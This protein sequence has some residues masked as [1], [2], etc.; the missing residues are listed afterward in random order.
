MI[1]FPEKAAKSVW[2]LSEPEIELALERIRA[3]R[4]DVIPD[5]FSW[6]KVLVNFLDPKLYGFSVLFFLLNLVS[7]SMSYFL[8]IILESGMG[9][10]EN[11]SIVLSAPV[12]SISF[13]LFCLPSFCSIHLTSLQPYYWAVIPVLLTS[14]IGDKYRL[15]GPAIIFNALVLIAG[16]LMFGLSI[17]H[18]VTVRYIGTYL[19]TGAYVSNWAALNAYQA[20]NIVGQWKRVA[21]A[22]AVTAC[23]GLGGIAGSFIVRQHE[24]P[25]YPTAVWVSI[26]SHILMIAIVGGF[27]IYFKM[28]N[29]RQRRRGK[30][31]EGTVRISFHFS[32][33]AC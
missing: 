30:I 15:R 27:T 13:P 26:G 9:F 22:A 21:I 14:L 11:A 33:N 23:N 25:W 16:F 20:N 28:E 5:P 1:D 10:S 4:G 17:S 19:A 3:D 6:K 12:R 29:D 32:V 24:A 7:T 18:Q 8:P 31:I 2:F